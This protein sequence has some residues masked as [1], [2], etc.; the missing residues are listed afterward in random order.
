MDWKIITA[1]ILSSVISS[2]SVSYASLAYYTGQHVFQI[3][4][5]SDRIVILEGAA[6]LHAERMASIEAASAVN[7]ERFLWIKESLEYLRDSKVE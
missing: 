3:Y 4:S 1:T 6:K 7:S 2:A 5:N